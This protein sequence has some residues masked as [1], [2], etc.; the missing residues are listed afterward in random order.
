MF[1][2]VLSALHHGVR[3]GCHALGVTDDQMERSFGLRFV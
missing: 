3:Q 2:H 1:V